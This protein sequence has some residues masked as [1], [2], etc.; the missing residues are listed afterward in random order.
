M[1][2]KIV[3]C[4]LLLLLPQANGQE[5]KSI[6]MQDKSMPFLQNQNSLF[7][8]I[9]LLAPQSTITTPGKIPNSFY[10]AISTPAQYN[11]W[12]KEG[13]LDLASPWKLQLLNES[14]YRTMKIILES[15]ELG[16]VAYI[17][18]RHIKKY[19]LN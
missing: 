3:A 6:V 8:K 16:G 5:Q 10:E 14:K 7:F 4:L 18:Y 19:G 12:V 1:N 17:A 15:I 13:N 9:M 2:F 11:V